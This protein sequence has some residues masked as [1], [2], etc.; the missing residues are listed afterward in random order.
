MGSSGL[1]FRNTSGTD[2][3]TIA[4]DGHFSS[5]SA[6][7]FD[8]DTTFNGGSNACRIAGGSD[9]RLDTGTWTG[10]AYAKIQHHS[11]RLYIAG[12]S[13]TYTSIVLRYYVA[14]Q[15]YMKINGGIR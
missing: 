1:K 9:I 5:G 4:N 14:D 15:I 6:I 12:G 10:N 11:D 13:N 2:V 3:L 8:S 7:V